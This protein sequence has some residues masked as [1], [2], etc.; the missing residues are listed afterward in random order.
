MRK[1]LAEIYFQSG[2]YDRAGLFWMLTEPR[3]ENIKKCQEIYLSTVNNSGNKILHDFQF[4]GDENML[5]EY[6]KTK[7][8]NFQTDSL[9]KTGNVPIFK[10]KS[11]YSKRKSNIITDNSKFPTFIFFTVI[12]SIISLIILGIY[13]LVE[14]LVA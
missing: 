13:K 4:R 3:T 7:L 11:K 8:H 10:E 12:I 6:A 1:K 5:N 14:I 2:F 9:E